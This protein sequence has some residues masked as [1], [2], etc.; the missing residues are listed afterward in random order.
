MM[1]L[2]ATV[3]FSVFANYIYRF[4]KTKEKHYLLLSAVLFVIGVMAVIRFAMGH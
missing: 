3:C 4:I 1:D 2:T